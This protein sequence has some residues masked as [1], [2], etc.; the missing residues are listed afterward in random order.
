MAPSATERD[1]SFTRFVAGASPGLMRTAWLLWSR[2]HGPMAKERGI[3]S[4]HR[5]RP[6]G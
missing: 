2:S 1:E 4:Q 5:D 6:T 3:P